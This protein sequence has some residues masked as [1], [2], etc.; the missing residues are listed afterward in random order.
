MD[1]ILQKV[2]GE[3]DTLLEPII[4]LVEVKQF[5][6]QRGTFRCISKC[7]SK[8]FYDRD[9]CIES[10]HERANQVQ[11]KIRKKVIKVQKRYRECAW[12]CYEN[13]DAGV[14]RFDECNSFCFEDLSRKFYN[15]CISLREKEKFKYNPKRTY[16]FYEE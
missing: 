12:G 11:E 15:F 6:L 13:K 8:E 9:E 10:C 16:Y 14:S 1:E 5:Q 3:I 7:T 2:S 4:E